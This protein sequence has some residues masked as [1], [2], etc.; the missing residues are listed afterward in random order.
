M[1]TFFFT[2][3]L[4]LAWIGCDDVPSGPGPFPESETA[5]AQFSSVDSLAR[6]LNKGL[7]LLTVSGFSVGIDGHCETWHY[8]FFDTSQT[9]VT[10]W[11]HACS[12]GFGFD[13]T[14]VLPVGVS[15]ITGHWCDS[16]SAIHIAEK[17]GGSDFRGEYPDYSIT[18]VLGE[19]VVPNSAPT[20]W[21]TYRCM[22][23]ASKSLL[24]GIDAGTRSVVISAN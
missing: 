22:S 16:D 17:N 12:K 6:S 15:A 8:Q 14:S 3:V 24:V 9:P 5:A 4:A 23:D 7:R 20:W 1:K 13:S 2:F 21:I 18:A 10:Y 11:F 19:A